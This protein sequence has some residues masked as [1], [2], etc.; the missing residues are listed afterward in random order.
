VRYIELVPEGVQMLTENVKCD[1]KVVQLQ[2]VVHSSIQSHF[3][4]IKFREENAGTQIDAHMKDEGFN[5]EIRVDQKTGME[6]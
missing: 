5:I 6:P 1:G 4:G 2:D 3:E